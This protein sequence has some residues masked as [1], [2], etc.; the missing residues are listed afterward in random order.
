[1]KI[2]Q[3]PRWTM[4]D[5]N[6]HYHPFLLEQIPAGCRTALDVGCGAGL[7]ARRVAEQVREVTAIDRDPETIDAARS[8]AGDTGVRFLQADVMEAEL[9]V[10]GFDFVSCLSALHH[11]PLRPA[12]ER[13]GCLVAPGG[14][15]AVLGL[16]RVATPID[17]AYVGGTAL[18]DLAVGVVRH[19]TQAP[20]STSQGVIADWHDTLGEIR[21]VSGSL[22]PGAVIRRRMYDRYSLVYRRPA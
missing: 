13:L 22:L 7:F 14:V 19:R 6:I 8:A 9:P 11:M 17:Y 20:V 2:P 4:W 18:L 3:K 10:G 12:L 21:K 1:M 16:Y 15:L 5:H